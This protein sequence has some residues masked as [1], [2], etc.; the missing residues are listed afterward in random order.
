MI[1]AYSGKQGVIF[2]D[3]SRI[4]PHQILEAILTWGEAS[5]LAPKLSGNVK[6]KT[7]RK[8]CNRPSL[9]GEGATGRRGFADDVES[10]LE[11]LQEEDGNSDR[12]NLFL[13]WLCAKTD[14]IRFTAPSVD[15]ELG[16]DALANIN[17]LLKEALEAVETC[18]IKYFDGEVLGFESEAAKAEVIKELRECMQVAAMMIEFVNRTPITKVER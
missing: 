13:D 14:S 2:T 9:E 3:L 7:V 12:A 16:S 15:D 10:F 17:S 5:R 8:Y 18:R 1:Q 6:A 11:H 4:R